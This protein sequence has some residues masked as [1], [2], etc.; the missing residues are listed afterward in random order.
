[1]VAPIWLRGPVD[2]PCVLVLLVLCAVVEILELHIEVGFE[3]GR[4]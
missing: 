2:G 4:H 1:M 3:E